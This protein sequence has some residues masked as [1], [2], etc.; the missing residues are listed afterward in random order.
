MTRED[1]ICMAREAYGVVPWWIP[2]TET[3]WLM[4]ERFV[5][6]VAVAEREACAMLVE[7][8]NYGLRIQPKKEEYVAAIRE[9][10]ANARA[11][12]NA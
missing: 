1:I 5:S 8:L 10:S 12:G 4:L 9:R 6:M 3:E 2:K 11:K 7:S